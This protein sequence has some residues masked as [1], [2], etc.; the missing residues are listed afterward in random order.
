MTTADQCSLATALANVI[1]GG[2][3]VLATPDTGGGSAHVGNWSVDTRGTSSGAPVTLTAP[4]G[5]DATLSARAGDSSS[6]SCSTGSCDRTIRTVGDMYLDLSN[7]TIEHGDTPVDRCDPGGLSN[8]QGGT[9]AIADSTF[10]GNSGGEFGGAIGN[11]DAGASNDGGYGDGQGT[12]TVLDSTFSNNTAGEQGGAIDSGD[13]AGRGSVT[14]SDSTFS[15]N[16]AENGGAIE[17]GH[18][19]GGGS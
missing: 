4:A 12:L 8:D 10:T 17:S 16:A 19:L 7:V 2:T 9:V 1:P 14:V 11:A 6:D 18:N 13:E 15:G 5:S 3:V